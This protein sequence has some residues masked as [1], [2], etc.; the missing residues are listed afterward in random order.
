MSEEKNLEDF[1]KLKAELA[2]AQ[3]EENYSKLAE[4]G[5]KLAE[6]KGKIENDAKTK[7]ENEFKKIK[8][9]LGKIVTKAETKE[10]LISALV[11]ALEKLGTKATA[12]VTPTKK[13]PSASTD[14]IK[15]SVYRTIMDL[16]A[17]GEKSEIKVAKIGEAMGITDKKS[18]E[19]KQ[20]Q[21]ALTDLVDFERLKKAGEKAGTY[22]YLD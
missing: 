21:I 5:P 10:V 13:K 6:L 9:E 14:K 11:A 1:N 20:L 19:Y 12:T 4:I 22:Y 2:K 8:E 7:A 18:K 17:K 16:Q 15:A 3:K